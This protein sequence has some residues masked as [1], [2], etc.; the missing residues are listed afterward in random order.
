MYMNKV[1]YLRLEF[2]ALVQNGLLATNRT[3]STAHAE[4]E[5]ECTEVSIGF[6]KKVPTSYILLVEDE[7]DLGT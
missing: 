3:R 7:L 6:L 4:G 1:V 5:V 2:V